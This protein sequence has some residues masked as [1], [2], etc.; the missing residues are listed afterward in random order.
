MNGT[1][2]VDFSSIVI[3]PGALGF[4]P[5]L[6]DPFELWATPG[7]GFVLSPGVYTMTLTGSNSASMGS[8]A[9]NVGLTPV[10]ETSTTAMLLAGV[11]IL[12]LLARRRP[13]R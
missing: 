10:P 2:D 5:V 3:A 12:C 11:G 7:A 6:S 9:G 13:Q 8:Y 1:Q 4:V